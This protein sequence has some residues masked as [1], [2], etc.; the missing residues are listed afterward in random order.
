MLMYFFSHHKTAASLLSVPPP[1]GSAAI[2]PTPMM[3]ALMMSW[4]SACKGSD[5]IVCH[6]AIALFGAHIASTLRLPLWKL[7]V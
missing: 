2:Q 3:G 6:D 1:E 4:M 7:K 5:A